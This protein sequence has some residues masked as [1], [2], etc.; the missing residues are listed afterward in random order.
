MAARRTACRKRL[1]LSVHSSGEGGRR[2]TAMAMR[3]AGAT[4]LWRVSSVQR[5]TRRRQAKSRSG[6]SFVSALFGLSVMLSVRLE[7]EAGDGQRLH[8][9]FRQKTTQLTHAPQ[10]AARL[11]RVVG[12]HCFPGHRRGV[13]RGVHSEGAGN[14]LCKEGIDKRR[15]AG[16]KVCGN[17]WGLG[18]FLTSRCALQP[19]FL[20][21]MSVPMDSDD[22]LHI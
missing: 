3:C 8:V 5:D 15:E 16:E 19:W 17:R 18:T 13:H 14:H 10:R 7:R 6:V 1:A 2:D 11:R 12:Q 20:Q 22:G 21:S 9:F 4:R